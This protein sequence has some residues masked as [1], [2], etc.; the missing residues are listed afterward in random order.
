MRRKNW[1]F[2]GILILA[3]GAGNFAY[4]DFYNQTAD[5]LNE[6]LGWNLSHFW[7]KPYLLGL[8]LRGGVRLVYQADLSEAKDESEAMQGLR[9]VIEKRVNLFGVS[10]PVVQIQGSDRLIVELPG[11]SDVQE[12]IEMIGQTPY[13]EFL[14]QRAEEDS[15]QV[16]DK[17]TEVQG[18]QEEGGDVY[19]VENWS[20]ALEHPYFKPTELTGRYLAKANVTFD[21]S[22]N[23]PYVELVFNDE[24]AKLFEEITERNVQKPLAIFLDGTSIVDTTGDGAIDALDLYAPVVQEKITGGKAIITG[25]ENAK[26]AS[27]IARRLNLGALPVKI[28]SPISQ[29]AIGPALGAESLEKSL[30]AGAW[31][32]ILVMIFMVLVYR[33]PGLLASVALVI[34]VAMVLSVFKLLPVTL[35]LAGIGGFILSI[36]MAVD[37]NILIFSRMK[38]E[39]MRGR[40][41]SSALREGFKRAWLS[42]RDSNINSLLVCAILF[43]FTTS[44]VKGFALALAIGIVVSMFSAIFVTRVLLATFIG[45][46][47]ERAKWLL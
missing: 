43:F 30:K 5:F 12:A 41:I 42:I 22:T 37:A 36:G 24:G 6:K 18:V 25:V 21:P 4:P 9:D 47:A 46:W 17:I 33:L 27:E 14:E 19:K 23:K 13:L 20:L 16:M 7:T 11:V 39:L 35:S 2:I 3:F 8:D 45:R 28:G 34:Y 32:I 31:G 1:L 10:E 40:E 38:E 29:Q 44:F 26:V 15:R